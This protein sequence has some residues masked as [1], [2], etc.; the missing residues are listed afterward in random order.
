M[1]F[2]IVSHTPHFV[3][4]GKLFAYGPYVREM[5]MWMNHVSETEIVAP[6]QKQPPGAI[7]QPYLHDSVRL[8]SIPAISLTSVAECLKTLFWFPYILFRLIGAMARADHIH[9]RCPGSIGLLGCLAQ[10]FFPKKTKTAKYAG[11]WDPNAKQPRSYRFQK[12]LLSHTFWTKNMQ[13]LVYGEWPNQ[14]K[15]IRTFFTA[16][17]SEEKANTPV[18][19][20]SNPPYQ[21][22]FVGSLSVG[23]RPLYAAQ[24]V[25]GLIQRG[26]PC[27]LDFFGDGVQRKHLEAFK[28]DL[29]DGD[30]MNL[31]GNQ[32][33]ATVENAYRASDFLLLA[34]KSEGWPKVVAEA[35]FWGVIPASTRVSCVP[36]ML[37][38]GQ[39][40]VLLSLEEIEDVQKLEAVINEPQLRSE[41]IVSG[42][43]WSRQYTLDRFETEIKNL[44]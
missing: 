13:V 41:M 26:H 4:Q 23:K 15:N 20:R 35:M 21:F 42:Q 28:K 33:A 3:D 1:K 5:N 6:L 31:H 38:E 22:L 44:L 40:G 9:L 7:H 18:S 10:L 19:G 36:W 43:Q 12:W 29:E 11:N 37:G 14:S 34:S 16:T 32:D 17:Y 8:R 30:W 24:L 39:R 27:Q 2:L 25:H